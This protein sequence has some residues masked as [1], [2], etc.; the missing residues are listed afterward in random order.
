LY[1]FLFFSPDDRRTHPEVLVDRGFEV[2]HLTD[3]LVVDSAVEFVQYR[4]HFLGNFLLKQKENKFKSFHRSSKAFHQKQFKFN[5]QTSK[6]CSQCVDQLDL[7][8]ELAAYQ[9]LE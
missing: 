6:L 8:S 5:A 1:I 3:G 7:K 9:F 4:F 2:G